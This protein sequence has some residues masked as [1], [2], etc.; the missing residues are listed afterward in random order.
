MHNHRIIL[1]NLNSNKKKLF[2]NSFQKNKDTNG[3]I[4]EE[5]FD[6]ININMEN[7]KLN[8]NNS[9]NTIDNDNQLN[10]IDKGNFINYNG[11]NY[12]II[13]KND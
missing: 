7:I 12:F 4:K 3:K 5:I 10:T 8:L 13:I 9:K 1:N 11:I 6:L 2:Y